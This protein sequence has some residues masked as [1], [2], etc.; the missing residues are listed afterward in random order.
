VQDSAVVHN[1]GDETIGG[2]KTFSG[3]MVVQGSMTVAGSWQVESTGPAAPMTVAGGD[4]KVG[5]DSDGKLKV[6]EN[7]ATVT[8]IAKVSQIPIL[9][10]GGVNNSSQG[11]L[12]LVPGAN[13]SVTS[14]ANGAVT[15]AANGMGA[16]LYEPD[17]NTVEQR[18]G[19][20]AQSHL[21]YGTYTDASNYERLSTAYNSGTGYYELL[22]QKGGTGTQHGVCLGG[23]GA[24]NWGVDISGI[25]K[26]MSDNTKDIGGVTAKVRD[27]YVGRNLMT[28]APVTRYNGIAT[29]GVGL[30]AVYGVASSTG[31]TA[32]VGATTLCSSTSCGAGQ[33]EVTYYIDSTASC[34]TPGSAKVS[35]NLAWTDEAGGKV[36]SSVPL[37]GS[38][39][40]TANALP[41]GNTTSYASGQISLW[42]AGANAIT[43]QTVYTPCSSGT[44]T[45]SLRI[46]VKQMQ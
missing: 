37:S 28:Y 45:Y 21:L 31:L 30:E 34:A 11:T 46:A 44:G 10:T 26:P 29:A 40:V 39:D 35:L 41:L 19:T 9:Q 13:V 1:T 32:A 15:I 2:T 7:G 27:V 18:N 38:T 25:L 5:F 36:Q 17:A 42:S 22:P 3:N 8:E 43:Y 24:C 6:S 16:P 20:T 14:G 23:T 12:N 4:S 33:Y